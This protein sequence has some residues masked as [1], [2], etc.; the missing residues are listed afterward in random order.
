MNLAARLLTLLISWTCLWSLTGCN[1]PSENPIHTDSGILWQAP[2][3]ESWL[4]VYPCFGCDAMHSESD[5][6]IHQLAQ[7]AGI[8]VSYQSLNRRLWLEDSTAANELTRLQQLWK[9]LGQPERVFFGGFSSGGNMALLLADDWA[10][11]GMP[12]SGVFAVDSPIDHEKLYERSQV[13]VAELPEDSPAFP[14]AQMIIAIS[15]QRF[16]QF[17]DVF[18]GLKSHSPF[19]RKTANTDQLSNLHNASIR[20]YTEPDTI[21]WQ[22]HRAASYEDLNAYSFR[23]LRR[24]YQE[25]YPN[26]DISLIQTEGKGFRPDGSRHPHSWSIVDQSALV[27]WMLE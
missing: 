24:V 7:S 10:E 4:V 3:S 27:D 14:E 26:S 5:F 13:V 22:E 6:G 25:I 2:S 8:S 11:S 19:L 16:G 18:D 21:W 9:D 1:S 15:E 17:P 23:E 12:L 20:L